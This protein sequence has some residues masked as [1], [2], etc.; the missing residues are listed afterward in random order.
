MSRD[1]PDLI[2]DL[3]TAK[4]FVARANELDPGYLPLQPRH[5]PRAPPTQ[6]CPRPW[7]ATPRSRK[8]FFDEAL[9]ATERKNLMIQFQ[10]ARTYAVN[11]SNNE[12]V[13][14]AAR[15]DSRRS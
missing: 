9:A 10:M 14:Q 11:T 3:P 13:R 6:R 7:A 8:Q 2:V 1:Q 15:R 4:A 5:V 12:L